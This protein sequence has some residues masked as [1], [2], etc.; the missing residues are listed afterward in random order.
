MEPVPGQVEAGI[1]DFTL[2]GRV[3]TSAAQCA[4]VLP[5]VVAAFAEASGRG[6]S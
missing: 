2:G 3:P 5:A 4:D 1:T 6:V